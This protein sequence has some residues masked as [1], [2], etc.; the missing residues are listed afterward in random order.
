MAS[1][2]SLLLGGPGSGKVDGGTL[3]VGRDTTLVPEGSTSGP[4]WPSLPGAFE[5]TAS[6]YEAVACLLLLFLARVPCV[7]P[8]SG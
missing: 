2:Q 1:N 5:G 6:W 8:P 7:N 3:A 4:P